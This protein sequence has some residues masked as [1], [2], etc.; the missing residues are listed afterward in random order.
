MYNK[1]TV[2]KKDYINDRKI[3]KNMVS[4]NIMTGLKF[5]KFSF[6]A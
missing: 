3:I 2:K 5:I 1:S 4:K 6:Y